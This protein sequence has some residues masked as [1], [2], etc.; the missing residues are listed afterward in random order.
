MSLDQ[1]EAEF[2]AL[3]VNDFQY[4]S[5]NYAS[6]LKVKYR[7]NFYQKIQQYGLKLTSQVSEIK[8]FLDE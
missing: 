4:T 7:N 8:L 3:Y 2:Y 5:K 6:T 1:A